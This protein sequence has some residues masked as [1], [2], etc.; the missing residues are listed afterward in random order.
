[1]EINWAEEMGLW[2][3]GIAPLTLSIGLVCIFVN[4]K[5][6]VLAF[7]GSLELFFYLSFRV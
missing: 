6:Q 3:N 2:L 1:M 4:L 5:P 7:L